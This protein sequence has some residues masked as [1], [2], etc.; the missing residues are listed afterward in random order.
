MATLVVERSEPSEV[1]D[2]GEC[3]YQMKARSRRRQ[4]WYGWV[5]YTP[6]TKK[7]PNRA[8]VQYR[9]RLYCEQHRPQRSR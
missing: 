2:L 9:G 1:T 6:W 3:Q 4:R 7:C 5:Y 8:V